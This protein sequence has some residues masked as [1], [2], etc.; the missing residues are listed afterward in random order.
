M[1]TLLP[2]IIESLDKM[3]NLSFQ[4]TLVMRKNE[5]KAH[6]GNVEYTLSTIVLKHFDSNF[7]SLRTG[8]LEDTNLMLGILHTIFRNNDITC[9][10][11][12]G[13]S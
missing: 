6:A 5:I 7:G 11:N 1:F 4:S 2:S 12:L 9:R 3:A 13:L 8:H 10:G